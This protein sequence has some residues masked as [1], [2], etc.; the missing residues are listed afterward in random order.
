MAPTP[1]N[2]QPSP[3][4]SPSPT[5]T[6]TPTPTP[7]PTKLWN[8][9]SIILG[10]LVLG[11]IAAFLSTLI[12]FILRRRR[13]RNQ[14]KVPPEI[15]GATRYHPFRAQSTDKT[16]LLANAAA[17]PNDEED[18][19]VSRKSSMFSRH[20]GTSVSLYIDTDV[21]DRRASTVQLI[22]LQV[23]PVGE[24][25]DTMGSEGTGVSGW[26][27][28]SGRFS[29]FSGMS[30]RESGSVRRDSGESFGTTISMS[31]PRSTRSTS[32][33]YYASSSLENASMP[34]MPAVPTIVHTVSP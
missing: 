9:G 23:T 13:A 3:S 15:R 8:T 1:T 25:G 26:T 7:E 29:G 21:V 4:P 34:E 2:D 11:F 32:M 17:K 12:I 19:A 20:R 30:G 16:S 14:L 18:D 10:S 6:P 5:T 24:E 27:G 33:R 22:P 31:R 28:G